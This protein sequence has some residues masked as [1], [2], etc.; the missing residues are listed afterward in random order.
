MVIACLQHISWHLPEGT[1]ENYI[2]SSQAIIVPDDDDDDE[3]STSG[4]L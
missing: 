4:Y 1:E 2:K 3:C